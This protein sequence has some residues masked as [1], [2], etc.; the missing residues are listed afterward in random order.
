MC[1]PKQEKIMKRR[2]FLKIIGMVPA[3]IAVPA[4][5]AKGKAEPVARNDPPMSATEVRERQEEMYGRMAQMMVDPP[6]MIETSDFEVGDIVKFEGLNG[7][8]SGEYVVRTVHGT[9]NGYKTYM[10]RTGR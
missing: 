8:I 4:L 2:E 3:V 10:D 1:Q 6:I 9:S 5:A 7:G